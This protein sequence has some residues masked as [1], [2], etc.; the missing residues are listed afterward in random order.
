MTSSSSSAPLRAAG[1]PRAARAVLAVAERRPPL[2]RGWRAALACPLAAPLR[3]REAHDRFRACLPPDGRVGERIARVLGTLPRDPPSP[4]R[5]AAGP[6]PPR[7]PQAA[8]SVLGVALAGA[9]G[10]FRASRGPPATPE[11]CGSSTERRTAAFRRFRVYRCLRPLPRLPG[12]RPPVAR[13]RGR[14]HR[15]LALI[16]PR[17]PAGLRCTSTHLSPSFSPLQGPYG[18]GR[19]PPLAA[20]VPLRQ[21]GQ[22]GVFLGRLGVGLRFQL[23]LG[24][25]VV[26]VL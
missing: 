23:L 4:P 15:P 1:A 5:G 12:E 18:S 24:H 26:L 20:C 14:L 13:G 17:A 21:E 11:P 25:Q 3:F 10:P 7:R 16:S 22:Q 2:A 19:R 9:D 6:G 8:I